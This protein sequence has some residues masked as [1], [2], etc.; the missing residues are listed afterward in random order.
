MSRNLV[1]LFQ[2]KKWSGCQLKMWENIYFPEEA[3]KALWRWVHF[4]KP[5]GTAP[6][7]PWVLALHHITTSFQ[8]PLAQAQNLS[9]C[10]Q[11]VLL[12][13]ISFRL[14]YMA[15]NDGIF[16][17]L[18]S[19]TDRGTSKL[20][21]NLGTVNGRRISKRGL[22]LFDKLIFLWGATHSWECWTECY[23]YS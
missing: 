6:F 14:I 21:L 7:P 10:A 11:L 20:T 13:V 12:N 1:M 8:K 3:Y 17:L 16:F 4:K 9:L 22:C 5:L 15:T 19:L 23:F 18:P 2:E